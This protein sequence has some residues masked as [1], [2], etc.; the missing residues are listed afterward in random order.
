MLL[1]R[2]V[3]VLA[4]RRTLYHVLTQENSL[5]GIIYITS[6][7][8]FDQYMQDDKKKNCLEDSLECFEELMKNPI[9]SDVSTI[10]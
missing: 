3:N 10:V 8:S 6:L 4:G 5:H 2:K 1:D 7:A 9:L